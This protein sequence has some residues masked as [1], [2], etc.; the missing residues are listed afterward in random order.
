M[1]KN[2]VINLNTAQSIIMHMNKSGATKELMNQTKKYLEQVTF[3]GK[4]SEKYRILTASYRKLA[5]SIPG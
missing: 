3:S 1:L 4:P 5:K 2:N